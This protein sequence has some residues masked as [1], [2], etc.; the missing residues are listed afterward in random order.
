MRMS[1]DKNIGL[2]VLHVVGIIKSFIAVDKCG[3]V[4]DGNMILTVIGIA[5][6]ILE[7]YFLLVKI[8]IHIVNAV[9]FVVTVLF[10]LA[11]INS[12]SGYGAVIPLTVKLIGVEYEIFIELLRKVT[13]ALMVA[14]GVQYG[15][16]TARQSVGN[17][18]NKVEI[19]FSR[20][21]VRNITV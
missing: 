14:L 17:F 8:V 1:A 16:S 18:K 2:I 21:I 20:H 13:A 4:T 6:H 10:I 12:D 7:P 3:R 11:Y 5:A 19:I 9:I 15:N